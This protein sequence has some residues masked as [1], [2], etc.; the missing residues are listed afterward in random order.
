MTIQ[1]EEI[2]KTMERL[3]PQTNWGENE[4]MNYKQIYYKQYGKLPETNNPSFPFSCFKVGNDYKVKIGDELQ[5]AIV[6]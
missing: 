1:E 2:I 6:R 5:L 4:V 3:K